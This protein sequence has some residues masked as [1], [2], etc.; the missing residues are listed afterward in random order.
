MCLIRMCTY[1]QRYYRFI[2]GKDAQE[3]DPLAWD[4]RFHANDLFLVFP[5]H[6]TVYTTIILLLYLTCMLI[7]HLLT[8]GAN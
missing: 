5:S 4:S 3:M 1:M 2:F 7:E 8:F 6:Y